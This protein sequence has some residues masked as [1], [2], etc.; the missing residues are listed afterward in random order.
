MIFLLKL[1]VYTTMTSFFL[2]MGVSLT[3][4]LG[5]PGTLILPIST[6]SIDGITGMNHCVQCIYIF[7]EKIGRI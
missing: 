6:S 3:F 1:P 5:W 2:K 7:S 4:Y